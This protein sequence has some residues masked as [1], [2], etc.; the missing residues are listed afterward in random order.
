ML[1]EKTG[2]KIVVLLLLVFS[3]TYRLLLMTWNSFPPGADIGLH[4]SVIKSITSGQPSLFVNYYH[5]GG[6]ISG[7]NPGYHLFVALATTAM[8]APDYLMQSFVV[9]FFSAVSVLCIFLIVRQIWSESGAFIAAFLAIFAAGDISM[10]NWSGYPNLIAL[11]LISIIFY[12]YLQHARFSLKTYLV[13]TSLF[14]GALFLTH[15]FSSF[16]FGAITIVTLLVSAIFKK[17]TGLSKRQVVSW[18]LPILFGALLVSPYLVMSIPVYF[19]PEST[20]TGAVSETKQALLTSGLISIEVVL[21]SLIPVF[22]FF[23]FSKIY[24][25]R[26]I[27]MPTVLFAVWI[28]VPAI[29]T[30][31]H[32]LGV[33]LDYER[34]QYYMY[35][36]VIICLALLI[37]TGSRV[38]SQKTVQLYK[39]IKERTLK[40]RGITLRNTPKAVVYNKVVYSTSILCLLLFSMFCTPLLTPPSEGI[41]EGSF[42]Q[43]MTPSGY[44]AI[45]WIKTSTPNNSVFVADGGYGWWLSGFAQR[46]TLSAVNPQCLILTHEIEP[47][48][49]ATNIL[50]SDSFIDNGLMQVNYYK[51]HVDGNSFEVSARLNG[52]SVLYPV[53]SIK[54]TQISIFYRNNATAQHMNVAKLQTTDTQVKNGSNWASFQIIMENQELVF[55]Q[56]VTLYTGVKFAKISINVQSKA[57]DLNMDWLYVPFSSRGTP[58]Q[59][60]NNIGFVDSSTNILNQMIFPSNELGTA[61]VMQENPDY[62]ELVKNLEGKTTA[63]IEFFTGLCPYQSPKTDQT[64]Y[65]QEYMAN[66]ARTYLDKVSNTPITFFDYQTAIKTWNISYIAVTNPERVPRF[67]ADEFFSCVY[68]N[69]EIAIFKVN[70]NQN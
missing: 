39:M 4:E 3:F 23:V 52:S 49:I 47:A 48:Q 29:M 67:S 56:S 9:S 25:Q 10:L 33:Y 14:V 58:N 19:S 12:L 57:A 66:N 68:R 51:S 55:T 62:F 22:L 61:T 6:G 28:L 59:Y 53:L 40:N 21:L 69:D 37:E 1:V 24:K 65:I 63:Q 18:V 43:V 15:I 17:K 42:Y 35:A 41:V 50:N 34:F 7:T 31:S 13:I 44:A 20:I 32:V 11:V 5:M 60:S 30:Q 70:T 38:L 46:P 2:K 16:V 54:D 8:G 27:T 36:P 45:E 26:Y 64:R